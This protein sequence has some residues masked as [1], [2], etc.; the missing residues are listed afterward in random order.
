VGSSRHLVHTSLLGAHEP[1]GIGILDAK[2]QIE[3]R[4]AE[5]PTV[6]SGR[7]ELGRP[8]TTFARCQRPIDRRSSM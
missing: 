1:H 3:Q 4:I 5:S 6:R 8:V 2:H 7:P